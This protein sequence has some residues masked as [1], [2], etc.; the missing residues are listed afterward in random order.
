M[1]V[2]F[3]PQGHRVTQVRSAG[4]LWQYRQVVRTAVAKLDGAL[5]S[6]DGQDFA[7]LLVILDPQEHADRECI[8]TL[9]N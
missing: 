9:R 2:Q 1:K 6:G 8:S 3:R 5:A 7:F 4:A